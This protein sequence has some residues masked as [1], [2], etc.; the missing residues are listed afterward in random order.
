MI[1]PDL[2][3]HIDGKIERLINQLI[4]SYLDSSLSLEKTY[5]IIAAMH[6]LKQLKKFKLEKLLGKTEEVF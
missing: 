4:G 3:K 5:G 1:D 2:E 6:E